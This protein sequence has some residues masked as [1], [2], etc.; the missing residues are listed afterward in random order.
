MGSDELRDGRNGAGNRGCASRSG[1][2]GMSPP[3][4]SFLPQ[5]VRDGRSARR[6]WW[7]AFPGQFQPPFRIS[8]L[9]WVL[10]VLGA[11]APRIG[12]PDV[13]LIEAVEALRLEIAPD[14]RLAVFDVEIRRE[15]R[16]L[17]LEGE[18]DGGDVKEKVVTSIRSLVEGP[19]EDRVRVLPDP[20]LEERRFGIVAVSV[21]NLRR[22]PRHT[23]ELVSQV[24]MGAEMRLLKMDRTWYLAQAPDGYL[25][26]LEAAVMDVRDEAGL[27]AWRETPRLVF[28]G[29]LG[30]IREAPEIEAPPVGDLVIGA[31]LGGRLSGEGWTPVWL[32]DGRRGFLE[33][34]L[35][36]DYDRW[37][38]TRAATPDNIERTARMFLG[39][40]YLWGGNSAKGFDCSGFT[41]TVFGINGFSLSR[42]ASQQ[43]LMGRDVD[44]GPAFRNLRVG[45]LLFFGAGTEAEE[46]DRIVHVGI[47]LGRGEFIH[48]GTGR[49]RINS[50]DPEAIHYD[51]ANHR[52]F[53]RA[54]RLLEGDL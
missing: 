5:K 34:P 50:L 40:P 53:V 45:D 9:V 30:W 44:P 46:A 4:S 3:W 21:G 23:A 47:H 15:G 43:A 31:K 25:G 48:S 26:W 10:C 29:L 7:K 38:E 20:D 36:K 27:T 41:Q 28:T 49:V 16:V 35:L 51:E 33:S 19:V 32:P 14:P 2:D 8:P 11:C 1:A 42:D 22:E 54:K 52:R 13:A 39:V 24:L 17:I 37:Q 6:G 18:V 12:E